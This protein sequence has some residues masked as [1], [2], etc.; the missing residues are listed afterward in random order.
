[1]SKCYFSKDNTNKYAKLNEEK[2]SRPQVYTK[3]IGKRGNLRIK[4]VLLYLGIYVY[5]KTYMHTITEKKEA[6][7]QE[8]GEEYVGR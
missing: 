5:T 1:M 2:I 3:S 4:E 8:R 7:N 6:L